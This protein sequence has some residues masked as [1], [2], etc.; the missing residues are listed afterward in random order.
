MAK[1]VSD[2]MVLG[3]EYVDFKDRESGE[4]RQM[5]RVTALGD[6][7]QA[8]C[9]YRPADEEPKEGDHYQLILSADSKLKPVIKFQ[10]EK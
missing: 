3:C 1:I 6:D 9:F 5:A 4:I 8:Y 10:K 7:K 2:A